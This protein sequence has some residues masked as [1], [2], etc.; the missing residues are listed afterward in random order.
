MPTNSEICIECQWCCTHV[1]VPVQMSDKDMVL[2]L[3]FRGIELQSYGGTTYAIMH[4]VCQHLTVNG[5]NIYDLRPDV[6]RQYDGRKDMFH[7]EKCMLPRE[8]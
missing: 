5:C 4:Q 6:C 3:L 7:P 8:G 1:Y 2:L